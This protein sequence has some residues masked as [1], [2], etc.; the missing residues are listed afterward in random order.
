[1]S[2][3]TRPPSCLQEVVDLLNHMGVSCSDESQV[4][5]ICGIE[6]AEVIQNMGA[7]LQEVLGLLDRG[8]IAMQ[9]GFGGPETRGVWQAE[10]ISLANHIRG[11]LYNPQSKA[12]PLKTS[13]PLGAEQEV[14]DV[15]GLRD[16]DI[17]EPG[18]F[19]SI[20]YHYGDKPDAVH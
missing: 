6:A 16:T 8:Q 10:A 20:G 5:N 13:E 9:P 1:M 19:A 18:R 7:M 11:T 4:G 3:F 2:K 12:N 14:G 17:Q 15:D